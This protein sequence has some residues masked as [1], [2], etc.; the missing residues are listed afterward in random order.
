[1][2]H[3]LLLLFIP[4]TFSCKKE[5]KKIYMAT[6][7]ISGRNYTV[8]PCH[9]TYYIRLDNYSNQYTTF[10]TLPPYSGINL[11]TVTATDPIRVQLNW[12]PAGYCDKIVIDEIEQIK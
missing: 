2:K 1:M 8:G 11:R 12:H 3:L 6:A 4:V 7:T 5:K 9:G 10:D